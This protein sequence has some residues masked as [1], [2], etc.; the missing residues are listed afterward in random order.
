MSILSFFTALFGKRPAEPEK[1]ACCIFG[2]GNPG[3]DYQHNRH[4][5]GFKV[6]D[7]IQCSL[8]DKKVIQTDHAEVTVGKTVNGFTIA[9]IKPLTFMNRSGDAVNEVLQKFA[10]TETRHIVVVDDFNIPLGSIRFR[11]DG[12]HGGHNGLKSIIQVIGPN[13]PRLRIGIGPLPNSVKVIDFVLGNFSENEEHVLMSLFPAIKEALLQF[14]REP[15]DAV[16]N[17]YNKHPA[18]P[19]PGKA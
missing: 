3:V 9:T 18:L 12:S 2:L 14:M 11:R 16:M 19:N 6:V 13:F 15:I 5:I 10:T 8:T 17:R 7:S 1:I 4:N